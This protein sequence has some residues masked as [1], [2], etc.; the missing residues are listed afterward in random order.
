MSNKEKIVFLLSINKWE[1]I[2]KLVIMHKQRG[3]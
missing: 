2:I 3:G 1:F